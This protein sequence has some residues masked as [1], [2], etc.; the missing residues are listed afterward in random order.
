MT[1]P[2]AR[3]DLVCQLCI[4]HIQIQG[5]ILGLVK[6]PWV[7]REMVLLS[8]CKEDLVADKRYVQFYAK[9]LPI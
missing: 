9:V 6:G 8:H 2:I 1:K 3:K 4:Y 7:I 5:V